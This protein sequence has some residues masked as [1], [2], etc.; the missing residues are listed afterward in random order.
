M[1]DSAIPTDALARFHAAALEFA[2]TTKSH[3]SRLE[4]VRDD[5]AA[6]RAKGASY[7]TISELLMSCGIDASDTCVMR[8]C[9]SALGKRPVRAERAKSR[10]ATRKIGNAAPQTAPVPN[11]KTPLSAMVSEAAQVALLDDLLT[12]P[13]PDTTE[14]TAPGGPRI[15]KIK[16][17]NPNDL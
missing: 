7:R 8:F 9:W 16:F 10:A 15:A 2:G 12:C 11:A 6:M 3:A 1:N 4:P 14:S 13:P 5:I 17:A